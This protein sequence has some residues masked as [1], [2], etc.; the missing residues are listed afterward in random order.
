MKSF[1]E[2]LL[3]ADLRSSASL[4]NFKD[5]G[6][7][8][9]YLRARNELEKIANNKQ[10]AEEY[11]DEYQGNIENIKNNNIKF[12]IAIVS[13]KANI[14]EDQ[15]KPAEGI[16]GSLKNKNVPK[17]AEEL[18]E[19]IGFKP[20]ENK[21]AQT[22]YSSLLPSMKAQQEKQTAEP[23]ESKEAS[24]EK[25]PNKEQENEPEEK[26]AGE[27]EPKEEKPSEE[28][29]EE[30]GDEP[31]EEVPPERYAG[32][33]PSEISAKI[34]ALAKEENEKL[35]A[36]AK[37]DPRSQKIYASAQN[38]LDAKLRKYAERAEK[39]QS[40]FNVHPT[41][42]SKQK[43]MTTAQIAYNYAQSEVRMV[44]NKYLRKELGSAV[45]LAT[46]GAVGAL[47]NAKNYMK[48]KIE[49]SQTIQNTSDMVKRGIQA[50]KEATKRG[51]TTGKE[52]I[53]RGV[54]NVIDRHD[55]NAIEKQQNP[56][57]KSHNSLNRAV[58][59]I[60]SKYKS[61]PALTQSTQAQSNVQANTAGQPTE[62]VVA[63]PVAQQTITPQVPQQQPAQE[64]NPKAGKQL[65]FTDKT[66]NQKKKK[67][68]ADEVLERKRESARRAAEPRR[69]KSEDK[70]QGMLNFNASVDTS[71]RNISKSIRNKMRGKQ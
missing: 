1:R 47:K 6:S 64:V 41:P 67:K 12:A 28:N 48:N 56:I 51:Y 61:N 29:G 54:Q 63:Q 5:I 55:A 20:M 27:P 11:K 19:K 43:A 37:E 46:K 14:K 10:H 4:Y 39:Q 9:N 50:G 52:A 16:Q 30:E 13:H 59:N 70:S 32:K 17:E 35:R 40:R 22:L 66:F 44:N 49:N 68:T 15:A 62:P 36:K 3:E 8:Q 65:H 38:E 33:S 31:A 71:A 34:E 57:E 69:K 23:E 60:I 58:Q 24:E 7:N 45:S 25:I 2:H 42:L 26:E 21:E 18:L 53:E